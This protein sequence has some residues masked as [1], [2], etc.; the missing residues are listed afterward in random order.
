MNETERKKF[1]IELLKKQNTR[2]FVQKAME[3]GFFIEAII[4]LDLLADALLDLLFSLSTSEDEKRAFY[5]ANKTLE[6]DPEDVKKVRNKTLV[7]KQVI[8]QTLVN[9][10]RKF[11][12]VRN[13]MAHDVF[14][15]MN[16]ILE[17]KGEYALKS[18]EDSEKELLL[19][20][21]EK[22]EG[23]LDDV[24]KIVSKYVE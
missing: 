2:A 16:L 8:D 19:K 3:N 17:K 18:F 1:A 5:T 9:R 21:C 4:R 20:E 15:S 23:L 6:L 24:L 14:G 7:E 11:K 13:T 10:I 12:H 22:G